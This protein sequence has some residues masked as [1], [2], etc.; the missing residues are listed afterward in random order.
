MYTGI[1]ERTCI[2]CQTD[3]YPFA[4]TRKST[5]SEDDRYIRWPFRSKKATDLRIFRDPKT[6]EVTLRLVGPLCLPTP[7]NPI[8]SLTVTMDVNLDQEGIQRLYEQLSHFAEREVST[9]RQ[10]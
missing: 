6:D 2:G 4:V 9:T 8:L 10:D 1:P 3:T 7:E 5:R